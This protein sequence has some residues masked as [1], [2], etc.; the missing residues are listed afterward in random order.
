MSDPLTSLP[1]PVTST[2][3]PTAQPPHSHHPGC[4]HTMVFHEDHVGYFQ[5]GL[6]LCMPDAKNPK[7]LVQH[8]LQARATGAIAPPEQGQP[9]AHGHSHAGGDH[10]HSHSRSPSREPEASSSDCGTSSDHGHSHAGGHGHSHSTSAPAPA[11]ASA[12]ASAPAASG[13]GHSHDGNHG[14]SHGSSES[15]SQERSSSTKDHGHSHAKEHAHSHGSEKKSLDTG[16]SHGHSHAAG[17]DHG[18]SGGNTGHVHNEKCGHER[19]WHGDHFDYVVGNKLQPDGSGAPCGKINRFVSRHSIYENIAKS[20]GLTGEDAEAQAFSDFGITAPP[21]VLRL[22]VSKGHW[23]KDKNMFRFVM[24]FFLTG[25]FFLVELIVG[26]AIGSLALISD[27]F[28]MFSDLLGLVV[29]FGA[30]KLSTSKNLT[31]NTFHYGRAEVVGAIINAVFLLSVSIIISL[32]AIGRFFSPEVESLSKNGVT[33]LIVASVGLGMNI[34][35]LF[36]FGGHGHSHSHGGG[37]DHGHGHDHAE[38]ER[39]VDSHGHQA[40]AS[41]GNL[42]IHSMFLHVLGDAL[43][44]V[45]A[46]VTGL[47]IWLSHSKYRTLADPVCTLAISAIICS[48]TIPLIRRSLPIL[49]DS[50][51]DSI[52]LE[53]L[54]DELLKINGVG[55]IH[56]LHVWSISPSRVLGSMHVTLGTNTDAN[57]VMIQMKMVCHKYSIHSTTIQPEFM[58]STEGRA[59]C[60]E[61]YCTTPDCLNAF[62]CVPTV[63]NARAV[64]PTQP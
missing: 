44:S 17:Q 9:K 59:S 29:G 51:P 27:A 31:I 15:K 14:H 36:I 49:L 1:A 12:P 10:G 40:H 30:L 35:G 34:I 57:V 8:S 54:K 22:F 24:M 13:C 43:G 41:H 19:V 53:G 16:S 63:N 46:I 60:I 6:L 26:L 2:T 50:V 23:Y 61:P 21:E 52:D 42:N 62:C 3:E 32:E 7:E 37:H 18:H 55:A 5:D 33:L 48:S 64:V 11:P 56:E 28:H 39:L 47:V 58:D 4:G 38:Q 25:S 20:Q 45:A